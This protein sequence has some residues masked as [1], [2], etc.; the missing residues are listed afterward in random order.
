MGK[1]QKSIKKSAQK[2]MKDPL[3]KE[4]FEGEKKII[5]NAIGRIFK[6]INEKLRPKNSKKNSGKN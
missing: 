4:V 2:V 1:M 3:A 5:R 6:R